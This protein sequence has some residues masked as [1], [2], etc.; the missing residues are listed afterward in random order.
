M[1]GIFPFLFVKVDFLVKTGPPSGPDPRFPA[2][3]ALSKGTNKKNARNDS[4]VDNSQLFFNDLQI[5]SN[6]LQLFPNILQ[7]LNLEKPFSPTPSWLFASC[8]SPS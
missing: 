2:V 4:E 7:L 6:N 8:V 3:R 1:R 5:I